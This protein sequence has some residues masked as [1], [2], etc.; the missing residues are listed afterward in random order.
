MNEKMK[1]LGSTRSVI[2]EI[3]EYGNKRK[4]EIGDDKVF[5][6][7]IGNPNVPAPAEE[8]NAYGSYRKYRP[9]KTARLHIGTGRYERQTRG[10]GLYK[11][12]IR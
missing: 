11:Q 1:S 9:R 7:S 6:F 8:Q 10:L 12:K 2:R 4:A 3:F 5:D